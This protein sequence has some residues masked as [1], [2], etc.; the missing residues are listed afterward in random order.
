[1]KNKY[2]PDW[3]F[4]AVTDGVTSLNTPPNNLL[5]GNGI[6]LSLLNA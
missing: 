5:A 2:A 1:M 4:R 3:L 6:V